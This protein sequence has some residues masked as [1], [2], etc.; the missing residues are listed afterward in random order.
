MWACTPATQAAATDLLSVG[1]ANMHW[2][3][4]AGLS[5]PYLVKVLRLHSVIKHVIIAAVR[6][7]RG[8]RRQP[9]GWVV[10]LLHP[11]H[12]S[13]LCNCCPAGH[14][15]NPSALQVQ[16]LLGNGGAQAKYAALAAD[17]DCGLSCTQGKL[18]NPT[19]FA[20]HQ[21]NP[22]HVGRWHS[23]PAS[24]VT[25]LQGFYVQQVHSFCMSVSGPSA[26]TQKMLC[27]SASISP[28]HGRRSQW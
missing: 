25:A 2:P 11:R 13:Q 14:Q 20:L 19:R 3:R 18:C 15:F 8:P 22:C 27:K 9:P 7:P 28:K 24:W 17:M 26:E 4:H 21:H 6:V 12:A 1:S 23:R 10:P 5:L 16:R